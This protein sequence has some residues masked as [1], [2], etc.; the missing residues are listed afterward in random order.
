MGVGSLGAALAAPS[1]LYDLNRGSAAGSGMRGAAVGVLLEAA[2]W[3]VR[4]LTRA[5]P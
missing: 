5:S 3:G 4:A 2:A 1:D